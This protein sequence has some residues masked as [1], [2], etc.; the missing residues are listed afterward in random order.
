MAILSRLLRILRFRGLPYIWYLLA[1]YSLPRVT[2][3][4]VFESRLSGTCRRLVFGLSKYVLPS[5]GVLRQ[6]AD[7]ES[8]RSARDW[9]PAE[10]WEAALS[11][12]REDLDEPLVLAEV[13]NDGRVK[14][15][16][17]VHG[18][19]PDTDE[20]DAETFDPR[21]R[22]RLELVVDFK[23]D[24]GVILI[25]KDFLGDKQALR[26]EWRSLAALSGTP[27]CPKIYRA[28]EERCH[29]YKSF[30]SGPTVRQRLNQA[31]ARILSVDTD[32]DPELAELAGVA[33]LEA[34]WKRGRECFHVLP[35]NF[36]AELEDH[37]NAMHRGRVTG[38]SLTFGNVVLHQQKRPWL[39]D[40]D[41]AERHRRARGLVFSVRR[42]RDR[43]LYNRIYGRDILTERSA[44]QLAKS[45]STP[46]SPFDLGCG[47]AT[48]GFWSVD[49]GTGRWEALNRRV[50]SGLIKTGGRRILDLGSYNA[51]MPLLML[52]AGAEEVVAVER[53]SKLVEQGEDLRRL[54]EWRD[55]RSYDGLDLRCADMRAILDGDWGTFDLVT[56]F[57]SLY[58]LEEDDMRRMV[59]RA[60]ELAPILVLQA[61]T[62]T[63]RDAADGKATKSSLEFLT[64]LL[65]RDGLFRC[66]AVG[67]ANYSRPL[68]IAE[69]R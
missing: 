48:R 29:L 41:L 32:D 47:V 25:R 17:W 21:R 7:P 13:D 18:N 58:Y 54:F 44:R 27:W 1:G 43:D 40:F 67:P 65:E 11:R 34:V 2:A 8:F 49:S 55:M 42:D 24:D 28:D 19:L 45:L 10:I 66:H 60:A 5:R 12:R 51:L 9:L 33:R 23:H 15:A 4:L 16:D 52:Q 61:K 63:R 69:R 56:A 37:I 62:D 38:F 22:H 39:I 59:R 68:L 50:L 53:S 46:Y 36:F 31:G 26:H 14:S 35:D 57:C 3:W 20:V 6:A 64:A 30:V